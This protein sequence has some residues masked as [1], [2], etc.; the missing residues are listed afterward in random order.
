MRLKFKSSSFENPALKNSDFKLMLFKIVH[1][2]NSKISDY[3]LKSLV[4]TILFYPYRIEG[5][6][7][8]IV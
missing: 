5:P 8:R 7:E 3:F 6:G 2:E 1:S 4:Y